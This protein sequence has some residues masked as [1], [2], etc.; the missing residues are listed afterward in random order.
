MFSGGAQR[1][2]GE[3]GGQAQAHAGTRQAPADFVRG[4]C[5]VDDS[6]EG[7]E[8]RCWRSGSTGLLRAESLRRMAMHHY[9]LMMGAPTG[10]P[11]LGLAL[12]RAP[13]AGGAPALREAE[14]SVFGPLSRL[15]FPCP[16]KC[17]VPLLSVEGYIQCP[18]HHRLAL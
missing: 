18:N 4:A 6:A 16:W 2:K 7:I 11:S 12:G 17:D 13:A 8:S 3:K 14:Y 10:P 1:V 5:T 9:A 15:E